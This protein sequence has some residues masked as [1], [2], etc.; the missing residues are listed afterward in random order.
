MR[1]NLT[2]T[3][4]ILILLAGGIWSSIQAAGLSFRAGVGYEF[5]SQEF[6]L[7]SLSR[8]GAD[9][10]AALTALKTTYL[11][12]VRAQLSVSYVP[13]DRSRPEL[14]SSLEQTRDFVRLKF[15]ADYRPTLGRLRLDWSG[16]IDWKEGYGDSAKPDDSYVYGYG[17]AR[18]ML[19]LSE[20]LSL[21]WQVRSDFVS[22]DSAAPYSFDHYR[23]GGKAG[24]LRTFAGFS[25]LDM[26]LFCLARKVPDSSGLEYLSC[27]AEMSFLGFYPRGELDLLVRV[28]SKN[29]NL[30]G[31]QDDYIRLEADIRNKVSLGNLFFIRQEVD[32]EAH[33]FGQSDFF[34]NNYQRLELNLVGGVEKHTLSA[35]LGPHF[36]VL[37]EEK[38]GDMSFGEDYC[39]TGL[40]TDLDY[41]N[42][43]LLFCSVES[44]LAFRNL[45]QEG[46]LHS[47]FL[48]ERLNLLGDW[49]ILG[50]MSLNILLS[51][52]WEWHEKAEE[53]NRLFLVSAGAYY[54]F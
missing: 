20:R 6:F 15:L 54:T 37:S 47:D 10:L 44:V 22:F 50:A 27:G 28:E 11:D 52:E 8:T 16:E 14:H 7:D 31:K 36:E 12:D 34:N 18:F 5:L 13:S 9:S 43:G 38:N 24:I 35:G 19:P 2:R 42:P 17:R 25:S 41:M 30:P 46:D 26:Y 4:L 33:S 21:S 29:Y 49:R 40:K 51:A 53:N 48:I 45:Y 32:L 39:E 1:S 23:L 3:R